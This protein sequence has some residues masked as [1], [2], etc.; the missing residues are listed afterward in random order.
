M[1]FLL[2]GVKCSFEAFVSAVGCSTLNSKASFFY[3]SWISWF[4][5][6]ITQTDLAILGSVLVCFWS[7]GVYNS[8]KINTKRTGSHKDSGLKD[9]VPFNM[10]V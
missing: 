2:K 1:H 9:D 6:P 10:N 4:G 3:F 7:M 5:D 8:K